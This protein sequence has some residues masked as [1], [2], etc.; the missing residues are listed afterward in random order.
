MEENNKKITYE[1]AYARLQQ[2][3]EEIEQG[4]ISIDQLAE[5]VKEAKK[6]FEICINKL[7]AIEDDISNILKKM[8][9]SVNR[10][11]QNH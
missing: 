11:T 8:P 7:T 6:L 10:N 4:D 5:K 1:Q 3:V 9:D 2:L